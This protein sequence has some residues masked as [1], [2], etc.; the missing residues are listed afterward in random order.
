MGKIINFELINHYMCVHQALLVLP[1]APRDDE[2]WS[3]KNNERINEPLNNLPS[4]VGKACRS[5]RMCAQKTRAKHAD[6]RTFN[7]LG[8]TSKSLIVHDVILLYALV[9]LITD[10]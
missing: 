5:Y 8:S 9:S 10:F 3:G 2:K 6:S 1:N 4:F 7:F